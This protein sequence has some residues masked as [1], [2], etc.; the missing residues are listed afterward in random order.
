MSYT[1]APLTN[2]SGFPS[3]NDVFAA[4]FADHP[5]ISSIFANVDKEVRKTYDIK[6]YHEAWEKRERDG[7]RWFFVHCHA[8]DASGGKKPEGEGEIVAWAKWQVP[9]GKRHD[10][11][12]NEDDDEGKKK[13]EKYPHGTNVELFE[14][15]FGKLEEGR[16]KWVGP[17]EYCKCEFSSSIGNA[18][19]LL[20]L[21]GVSF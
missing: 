8:E 14:E 20:R 7:W 21:V 13:G 3:M 4:A 1:L 18:D 9:H 19:K 2:P 16:R 12:E 6:T 11:G 5:V 17:K 15:F 10:E